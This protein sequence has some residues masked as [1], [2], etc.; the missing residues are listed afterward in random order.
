[1]F[2]ERCHR[3]FGADHLFC[4]HDGDKLVDAPDTKRFPSR[5]TRI[6]GAM[7]GDRYEVRGFIGKGAMAR[8]YLADDHTTKQP[9]AVKVLDAQHVK[10]ARLKARFIQEAKAIASLGHPNI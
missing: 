9:V 10:N 8:V 6:A 5:P 7:L 3:S 4:P 1:M 2:C